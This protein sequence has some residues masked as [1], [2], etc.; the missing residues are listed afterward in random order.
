[1]QLKTLM[2]LVKNNFVVDD[3]LDV[4]IYTDRI[5]FVEHID[6]IYKD[7]EDK[8]LLLKEFNGRIFILYYTG[9]TITS[10]EHS[11][12]RLIN[13]TNKGLYEFLLGLINE[14]VDDIDKYSKITEDTENEK[15]FIVSL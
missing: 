8:E 3:R 9:N 14:K 12:L 7:D 4:Y 5:E 15:D 10:I 13:N 2:K 1:M 11:C 6:P